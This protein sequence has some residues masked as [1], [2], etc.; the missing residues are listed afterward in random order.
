MIADDELA[1]L[2]RLPLSWKLV[3]RGASDIPVE[4]EWPPLRPTPAWAWGDSDGSGVR[5]CVVDS[6]IERGHPLVGPVDG[7]VAVVTEGGRSRVVPDDQGDACGHGTACAS[8]IRRL[9]P[10]CSLWSVR[11]LGAGLLGKGE[12]LIAGLRWA[13][14]EGFDL[15]NL[16]LST[17][18]RQLVPLLHDLADRAYFTRTLLVASAHNM[19]VESFPWRFSSVISV[20][21]HAEPDPFLFCYNPTPPVEFFAR[22]VN[23]PVAWLGGRE[24]H[25]SG[26]SFATPHITGICALM[27]AKHPGLT[28][29]QTKCLLYLTAANVRAARQPPEPAPP[30]EQAELR[31]ERGE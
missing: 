16:S 15:V 8:V 23:V 19:P 7:A 3:G 28:C 21:S 13:I 4:A 2:P 11:V 9:A 25:C 12:S 31:A 18:K 27:L 10:N 30:Q 17:T 22:G 29:F 26:N 24:L 5:V 6:G 14:A 1:G 20:G